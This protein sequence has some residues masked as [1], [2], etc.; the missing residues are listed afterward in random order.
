MNVA[1]LDIL[2]TRCQ[3]ISAGV[4]A[5]PLERLGEAVS[6]LRTYGGTVVHFDVMDGV[7]V[8][9]IT[10]GPG[11]V[12]ALGE[13]ILRDVHLM[14]ADPAAHVDAFANAGADIITIHA[15]ARHAPEALVAVRAASA[16]LVR[17]ILAGLAVM[18]GTPLDDVVPQLAAKPDL[19]LSLALD[20]RDGIAPDVDR[21]ADRLKALATMAAP[22]RPVLALDGGVTEATIAAAAASGADLI[23]SGSAIFCAPD[24]AIAFRTLTNAWAAAR[25]E[26]LEAVDAD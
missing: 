6:A 15:E 11:F 21:A 14:V 9:A 12:R 25:S 3:G 18:P 22:T 1:S 2:R 26:A 4:F 5:A 19:I 17:P 7:F 10:G 16:R 13:G 20:P 24:P 23:V 8:P